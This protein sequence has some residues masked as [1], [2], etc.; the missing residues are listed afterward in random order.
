MQYLLFL[1]IELINLL[2]Y[3]F[4]EIMKHNISNFSIYTTFCTKLKQFLSF[5]KNTTQINTVTAKK[6]QL[7]IFFKGKNSFIYIKKLIIL[8]NLESA[9]IVIYLKH[10]VIYTFMALFKMFV[11]T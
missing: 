8:L 3:G 2:E 1:I 7:F 11:V 10:F 5:T 6:I 9:Y 4:L